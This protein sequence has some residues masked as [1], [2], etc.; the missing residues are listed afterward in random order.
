V[1]PFQIDSRPR[2]HDPCI[3]TLAGP[4]ISVDSVAFS[5]AGDVLASGSVDGTVRLWDESTLRIDPQN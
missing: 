4:A 5:P 1:K 3:L 2:G